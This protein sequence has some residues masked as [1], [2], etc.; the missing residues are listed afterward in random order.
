MAVRIKDFADLERIIE[1][2]IFYALAMTVKEVYDI[3]QAKVDAYYAEYEPKKYVRTERFK[4]SLQVTVPV[5]NN[6]GYYSATVGFEDDYLTFQY[7]GAPD[8]DGN[9]PATGADVLY[10]FNNK[11]HGGTVDGK[12]EFWNEAMDEINTTHGSIEKLFIK[13][14]K[15]PGLPVK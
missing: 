15:T 10:H 13:H 7:P 4:D 14:L 2:C 9:I 1:G 11:L 3:L 5:K 8:W 6:K 12:H